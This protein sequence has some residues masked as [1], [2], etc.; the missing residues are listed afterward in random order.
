VDDGALGRFG[1]AQF[2]ACEA[3]AA[4]PFAQRRRIVFTA[5]EHGTGAVEE[6]VVAGQAA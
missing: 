4:F 5:L 2:P 6:P 3:H 1:P